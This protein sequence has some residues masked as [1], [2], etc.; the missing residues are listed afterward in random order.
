MW[1][2][3]VQVRSSEGQ[4]MT[5]TPPRPVV[6]NRKVRSLLH[7][8][9]F[10][11]VPENKHHCFSQAF[12]RKAGG[13]YWYLKGKLDGLHCLKLAGIDDRQVIELYVETGLVHTH[14][15]F[16]VVQAPK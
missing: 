8:I 11:C 3:S 2:W 5:S 16:L 10:T 7:A 4:L 13:G 1:A 6:R 9:S 15:F 14:G 12:E